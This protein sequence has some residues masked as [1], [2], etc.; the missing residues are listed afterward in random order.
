MSPVRVIAEP[1]A[2]YPH[3]EWSSQGENPASAHLRRLSWG[4]KNLAAGWHPA[5]LTCSSPSTMATG[6]QAL[7]IVN[8]TFTKASAFTNQLKMPLKRG[9]LCLGGVGTGTYCH[10]CSRRFLCGSRGL[11]PSSGGSGLPSTIT[12]TAQAGHP[13]DQPIESSASAGAEKHTGTQVSAAEL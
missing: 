12:A 5:Q 8:I 9:E 2:A 7:G 10:I 6:R 4:R 11:S 3:H 1:P 13:E